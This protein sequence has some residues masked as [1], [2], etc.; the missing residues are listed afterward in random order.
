MEY[1]KGSPIDF[2]ATPR[3]R[4]V[5]SR[6]G[7]LAPQPKATNPQEKHEISS[8][9]ESEW[10][11]EDSQADSPEGFKCV[12]KARSYTR[13]KPNS[14]TMKLVEHTPLDVLKVK[15]VSSVVAKAVEIVKPTP[16]YQIPKPKLVR[17]LMFDVKIVHFVDFDH[18]FICKISS[19]VDYDLS[20]LHNQMQNFYREASGTPVHNFSE[21]SVCAVADNGI[22]HRGIIKRLGSEQEVD[23]F[24]VDV[25]KFVTA[26]KKNVKQL[27]DRFIKE[28]AAAIK[29]CLADI[30]P[31]K[32]NGM[33]Y[34]GKAVKE[35]KKLAIDSGNAVR[36]LLKEV[37]AADESNP[38]IVYVFP[39]NTGVRVNINAMMVE[40][41]DC[42]ISTGSDSLETLEPDP[43]PCKLRDVP[44][45]KK[46]PTKTHMEVEILHIVSPNEF[47]A[48]LKDHKEGKLSVRRR[49]SLIHFSLLEIDKLHSETKGTGGLISKFRKLQQTAPKESWNVG[50][51]CLVSHPVVKDGAAE[52][53]R[54]TVLEKSVEPS[55]YGVFLIDRGIR[56]VVSIDQMFEPHPGFHNTPPIAVR[57]HIPNAS[58][59][60]GTK[61][62]ISALDLF[63]QIISNFE[64]ICVSLVGDKDEK[65]SLPVLVWGVVIEKSPFAQQSRFHNIANHIVLE[66]YMDGSKVGYQELE[67]VERPV[68]DKDFGW[69][70][71]VV[72][73]H[74]DGSF[75]TISDDA[76]AGDVTLGDLTIELKPH[77]I[78]SWIPPDAQ[79]KFIGIPTNVDENGI[80]YIHSEKQ[81]KILEDMKSMITK[82]YTKVPKDSHHDKVTVGQPVIVFNFLDS[83]KYFNVV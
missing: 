8:E 74:S 46:D 16:L 40:W 78:S 1:S 28:P 56:A 22:W 6:G 39:G 23:V 70:D 57:M 55:I 59:A 54:A 33:K 47:Y 38:A 51:N 36:V 62:T 21:G 65:G 37:A 69:V 73:E 13:G 25:G 49:L 79:E 44:K 5:A 3:G 77:S 10:S 19:K 83:C 15:T 18:F 60:G 17:L 41:M 61:W 53:S 26:D 68:S 32:E 27:N 9:S 30:K 66:G 43:Y 52:W 45:Q 20:K 82:I 75:S 72:S 71:G 80:I 12:H 34:P 50:D 64:S 35:F 67:K 24:L 31:K 58:P 11:S 14:P 63:K 76:G 48:A 7:H 29:C 2:G 4:V 81:D 42:A